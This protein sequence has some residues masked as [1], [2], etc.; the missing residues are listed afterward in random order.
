MA[1]RTWQEFDVPAGDVRLHIRRLGAHRAAPLVLLHGLGVSA[2]VWQQFG[3][4]LVPPYSALA[5]DLRGHGESDA[6]AAGYSP[7]DYSRD[8]AALFDTMLGAPA[9]VLGHSLGALVALALADMR[10]DLVSALILVDPPV[11]PERR[12]PDVASVYR[13]RRGAPGELE[14]YLLAANPGGGELL[15]RG[16]ARLFRQAAD[17]AFEAMLAAPPGH[18]EAWERAPRV[19]QPTLV[20]QGD[21]AHGGLLGDIAARSFAARFEQGQL[22]K[23]PGATHA[24]HASRPAELAEASLRFLAVVGSG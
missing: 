22:R 7:A 14:A 9:A 17:A 20:V 12:N 2:A 23:I 3:R 10:P 24:V 11:D 1:I 18:P 15:A 13:L 19:R 16:L 8:L 5:P 4:R 21:P 6:P